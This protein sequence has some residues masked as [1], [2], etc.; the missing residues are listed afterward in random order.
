MPDGFPEVQGAARAVAAIRSNFEGTR[1]ALSNKYLGARAQIRIRG[2]CFHNSLGQDRFQMGCTE[3]PV[4]SD[5][6]VPLIARRCGCPTCPQP[7]QSPTGHPA[8]CLCL[9]LPHSA[10]LQAFSKCEFSSVGCCQ[11]EVSVFSKADFLF[12][13]TA[14]YQRGRA[15]GIFHLPFIRHAALFPLCLSTG[16]A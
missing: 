14:K 10:Y 6:Q 4:C 13:V 11:L 7:P 2:V 12:S 16:L 9:C 3:A 5:T 8:L 1:A 15:V